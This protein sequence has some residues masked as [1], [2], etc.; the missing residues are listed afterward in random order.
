MSCVRVRAIPEEDCSSKCLPMGKE[1][2]D[3]A[4]EEGKETAKTT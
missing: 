2:N 1:Q 4:A 3:S